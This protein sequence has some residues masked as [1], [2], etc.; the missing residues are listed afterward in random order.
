MR[1]NREPSQHDDDPELPGGAE[2]IP[3]APSSAASTAPP[4]IANR[5]FPH[6]EWPNRAEVERLQPAH[7]PT[8]SWDRSASLLKWRI[9]YRSARR[10]ARVAVTMTNTSSAHVDS[11]SSFNNLIHTNPAT[12]CARIIAVIVWRCPDPSGSDL[13]WFSPYRFDRFSS[14][15]RCSQI[16]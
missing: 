8:R 15:K 5:T 3:Q 9:R 4:P 14:N 6:R 2:V 10:S 7:R 11:T 1:R 13:G 16:G 12:T